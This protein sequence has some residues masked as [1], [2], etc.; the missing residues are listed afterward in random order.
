[1]VCHQRRRLATAH[2]AVSCSGPTCTQP[3]C[4][5]WSSTPDGTTLPSAGRMRAPREGLAGGLQAIAQLLEQGGDPAMARL[6]SPPVQFVSQL[7]H[8][9]GGP[10]PGRLRIASG[11]RVYETFQV[12]AT[13]RLSCDR[14]LAASPGCAAAA[15]RS[16]Q[17]L[18]LPR[19]QECFATAREGGAGNPGGLG[20]E[21][22]A[23]ISKSQSLCRNVEPKAPLVQHWS[24]PGLACSDQFC[25]HANSITR[26]WRM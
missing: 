12:S 1:M 25:L 2:A 8:A 9:V 7:A 11:H 26:R 3:R 6:M 15:S 4:C 5:V 18:T 20:H 10:T 19:R 24:Q 16:R 17:G 13:R 23:A 14:A 21:S 22:G